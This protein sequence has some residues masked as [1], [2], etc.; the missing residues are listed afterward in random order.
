[1]D[2]ERAVRIIETVGFVSVKDSLIADD[3]YKNLVIVPYGQNDKKFKMEA[4]TIDAKGGN[5][6]VFEVKVDKAI[7]LYDQ[8]KD[9]LFN[10]KAAISVEEV[11][12]PAIVVGSLTKVSTSANW[13]PY[14]DTEKE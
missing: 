12:G 9:L 6:Q 2:M 3:S 10:E 7:V 4:S 8:P 11:N 5:A 14:Y 13:P 1:N